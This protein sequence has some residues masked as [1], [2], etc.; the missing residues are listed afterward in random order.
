[1]KLLFVASEIAPW[2]KTGGLGDVASALPDALRNA[3]V[4]VRVLVPAYPAM[5]AA[6]P[7]ARQIA[8]LRWLGGELPDCSL[9]EAKGS[10]SVKLWLLEQA[11]FERVGNPYVDSKGIAWPDNPLR[12]GLLSRVAAWL[13]TEVSTLAW[14]PDVLHCNDW[15]SALAPAYLAW[16]PRAAGGLAGAAGKVTPSVV[17]IHNLAFQ[18]VFSQ[19]WLPLLGLPDAAWN[20]HG[21]E[22]HGQLSFLKAGLQSCNR[23]TTV[24]PTYAREIQEDASGMGLAPL[25]RHRRTDL[26]GIINGIDENVWNPVVDTY[27]KEPFTRFSSRTLAKKTHN[28][29]QLQ[30]RFSL[31]ETA[32]EENDVPLFGVVSRLTSQKGLDLL[33]EI[34]DRLL[35]LPAQLILL[36]SGEREL[37]E[38][39]RRLAES[40]RM[41]CA[42]RFEF[43][44]TIAHC[45]EAGADCFIMP[46]RFEPCGLNQMYSQR[47]GTLPIVRQTGG[48]ADTVI[49]ASSKTKGCGFMFQLASSDDLYHALSRAA[50]LYR[51][52]TRWRRLQL[53]AMRRD[54]SWREPTAR[55]LD[56]YQQLLA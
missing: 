19:S 50:S 53:N 20:M 15:Q 4:D 35:K 10:N 45:I 49:D 12:F 17:S 8:T 25:L 46:S 34:G 54:F 43:D 42:V 52:R 16:L 48:L 33:A 29:L 7:R 47:Y 44:E 5:R 14:R 2:V 28:K 38:S 22:F 39:F 41:R 21:V 9:W 13:S 1:M 26:H 31:Q 3:G 51:E 55:Y 56:V 18:G 37:E 27:L 32:Y 6:F 36:G 30:K 23:I 24:S 11:L 40:D